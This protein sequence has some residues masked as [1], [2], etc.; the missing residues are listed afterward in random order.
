VLASG[1]QGAVAGMALPPELPAAVQ[2]RLSA[3]ADGPLAG[4]LYEGDSDGLLALQAMLADREGAVVTIQAASV[5]ECG[6][7]PAYRTDW[8]CEEVSTSIN[9]TAAGGNASLMTLAP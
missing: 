4:A 9:T 8:L 2:A 5:A 3:S 6:A 7:G 1:N